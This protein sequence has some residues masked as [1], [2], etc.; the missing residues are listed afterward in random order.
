MAGSGAATGVHLS[1]QAC[2]G[3]RLSAMV[4]RM[5]AMVNNVS[6]GAGAEGSRL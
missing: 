5:L 6:L 1:Y 2:R 4:E 3:G